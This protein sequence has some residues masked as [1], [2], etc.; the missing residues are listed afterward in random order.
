MAGNGE[1][2]LLCL[3]FVFNVGRWLSVICLLCHVVTPQKTDMSQMSHKFPRH[4]LEMSWRHFTRHAIFPDIM[5]RNIA[6]SSTKCREMSQMSRRDCFFFARSPA[7]KILQG[8]FFLQM[9]TVRLMRIADA[10]SPQITDSRYGV[11]IASLN[12]Q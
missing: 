5:L 4:V 8:T 2:S 12:R 1:S 3:R 7:K 11:A 9:R 6:I 10:D